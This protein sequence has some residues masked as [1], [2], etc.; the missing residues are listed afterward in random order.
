MCEH[1]N[2]LK[3]AQWYFDESVSIAIGFRAFIGM[4]G[5]FFRLGFNNLMGCLAEI[6][7]LGT[8]QFVHS[9]SL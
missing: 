5:H 1:D 4:N 2:K 6:Q 8:V 7:V 9:P 3:S